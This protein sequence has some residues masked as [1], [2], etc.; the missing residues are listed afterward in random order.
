M[1]NGI[2]I[3]ICGITSPGDAD[4][5]VASG[6]DHLGFNIYPR[7]P[8]H[9]PLDQYL[10]MRRRLPPAKRVAVCI[11]PSATDL[12]ELLAQDF[13][14]F[15]M[16]FPADTKMQLLQRWTEIIGPRRLWLAP[17]LTGI[18]DIEPEWLPLA[19][20]FLLDTCHADR[21]M[22]MGL[23]CDW[24][25]FKRH[26][27]RYPAKQWILTGGLD[28]ENIGRVINSSGAEFIDVNSGVEQAPGIKSPAKLKAFSHTLQ[29]ATSP[30]NRAA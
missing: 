18:A 14:Y 29:R 25:K 22:L 6:A 16:N 7:S 21:S 20:T 4:A 5:A 28:P 12:R 11:R 8:R 15:Q 10:A 24:S 9:A 19:D 13:D 2:K 30:A 3:K 27:E 23:A 26:R 1:I 17:R